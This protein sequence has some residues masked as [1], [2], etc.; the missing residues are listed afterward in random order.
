MVKNIIECRNEDE[1][2][3]KKKS[4]NIMILGHSNEI[5][6]YVSY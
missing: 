4:G 6:M 2:V 1:R 3:Q 5:H